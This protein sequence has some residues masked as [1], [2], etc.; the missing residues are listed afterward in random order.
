MGSL[1]TVASQVCCGDGEN[2]G[3]MDCHAA[4]ILEV[5]EGSPSAHVEL[6]TSSPAAEIWLW[7]LFHPV[8]WQQDVTDRKS[9]V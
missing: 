4:G 9:V 1:W 2:P 5:S 8:V 3:L 6:S 7:I